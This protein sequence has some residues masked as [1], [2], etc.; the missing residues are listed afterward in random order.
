[1]GQKS[2]DIKADKIFFRDVP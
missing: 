2:V 1:L